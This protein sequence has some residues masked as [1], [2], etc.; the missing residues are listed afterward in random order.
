MLNPSDMAALN[1]ELDRFVQGIS[2][3]QATHLRETLRLDSNS[4]KLLDEIEQY[5]SQ[6]KSQPKSQPMPHQSAPQAPYAYA[7]SPSAR[8]AQEHEHTD[9]F[10]AAASESAYLRWLIPIVS[11]A[12]GAGLSY[13]LLSL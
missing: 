5:E 8:Q 2:A 10:D 11:V 12:I 6:P 1:Q 7:E 4:Q 9:H 13:L 3:P